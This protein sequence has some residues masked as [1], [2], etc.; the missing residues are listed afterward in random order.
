MIC[1]VQSHQPKILHLIFHL[2]TEHYDLLILLELITLT[3]CSYEYNLRSSVT[4]SYKY[5]AT[6]RF[7]QVAQNMQMFLNMPREQ[8]LP[9][10]EACLRNKFEIS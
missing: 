10:G 9:D 7:H 4:G 2:P 6:F 8:I 1:N 3:V 5:G